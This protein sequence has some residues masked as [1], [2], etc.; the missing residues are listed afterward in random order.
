MNNLN[1]LVYFKW[2]YFLLYNDW[3]NK[4]GRILIKFVNGIILK[5]GM[6]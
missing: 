2:G 4:Y 1:F 6:D 3:G 5:I